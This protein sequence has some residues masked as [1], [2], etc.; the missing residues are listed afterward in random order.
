MAQAG[1][2]PTWPSC[3]KVNAFW[4]DQGDGSFFWAS[5]ELPAVPVAIV[6]SLV[7]VGLD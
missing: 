6:S 1:Q 2:A 3:K 4:E 7:P 5:T